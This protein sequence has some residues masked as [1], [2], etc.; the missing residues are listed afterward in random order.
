[1]GPTLDGFGVEPYNRQQTELMGI[2]RNRMTK[3]GYEE[4]DYYDFNDIIL[5]KKG[6]ITEILDGENYTIYSL[7]FNDVLDINDEEDYR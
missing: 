2:I 1:M 4:I 7:L 3:S 6:D 5:M